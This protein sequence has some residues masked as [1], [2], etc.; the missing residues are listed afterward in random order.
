MRGEQEQRYRELYEYTSDGVFLLDVVEGGRFRIMG[1][2]PA[3]ARLIGISNDEVYGKY[4]DELFPPEVSAAVLAN[5]RRCVERAAPISYEEVL[6][7]PAGRMSFFTTL[8]PVLDAGGRVHRIIGVARDV[9]NERAAVE[10]LRAS[11]ERFRQLAENIREVFWLLDTASNAL[12][13]VSPGYELV[14]GLSRESVLADPKS[15]RAVVHREDRARIE[16]ADALSRREPTDTTYRIVRPDGSERWIRSRTFPVC[17]GDGQAYRVVGVAD[18]ITELVRAEERLRQAQKLEAVGQLAGGVA[19]DFNNLLSV[20]LS[21]SELVMNTLAPEDPRHADVSE[22]RRAAER[23]AD[24]TRQLLTFSRKQVIQPKLMDLAHTVL[25]MAKM[26]QRLIGE[27]VELVLNAAASTGIIRA[28]AGQLEQIVVNLAVNARDAMRPDGGKLVLETTNVELG[29]NDATGL[30]AG[31]YVLLTAKDTG[32]GMDG[33]TQARIFEPFFTTKE[34]GKG[35]GLGLATVFG[36]VEQSGG[37]IRVES[38]PGKGSTFSIYFP[39]VCES[40]SAPA[41][42]D[43]S[44]SVSGGTETILLVEDDQQVRDVTRAILRRFGYVVLDAQNAG[45]ALL[46]CEQHQGPIHLLLTDVVMPRMSGRQ[47]AERLAP[48][49]PEMKVLFMSGYP[50][51]SFREGNVIEAGTSFIAKP[52]TPETLGAKVRAVIDATA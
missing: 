33:P 46:S 48:L 10:A 44:V 26:L 20:V 5:Y 13:Y 16:A 22:I 11:E 19:H 17:G 35:T 1:F 41:V 7:V 40:L 9:T 4:I 47:L 29:A 8:V 37:A 27:G 6:D 3:E 23:A 39:R 28:D 43:A 36:I 25:P 45:E 24:L 31:P 30:P 12:L 51:A 14:W 38:A 42:S 34:V 52:L 32:A 21:Y 50:D 49:R 2:N 15:W 18:D